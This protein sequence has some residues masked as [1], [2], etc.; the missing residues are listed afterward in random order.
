MNYRKWN[1]DFSFCVGDYEDV[2]LFRHNNHSVLL[3]RY[4][5]GD[6][7]EPTNWFGTVRVSKNGGDF[8]EPRYLT[9]RL[10]QKLVSLLGGRIN[11]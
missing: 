4:V 11:G 1:I 10:I 3:S 8:G 5:G 7:K 9:D 6:K 2:E